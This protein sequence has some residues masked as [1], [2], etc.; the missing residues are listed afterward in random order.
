MR[1]ELALSTDIDRLITRVQYNLVKKNRLSK[2]CILHAECAEPS[3]RKSGE[4]KSKNFIIFIKWYSLSLSLSVE[5]F[6]E[7]GKIGFNTH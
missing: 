4:R 3:E 2:I 5:W 6:A 7:G 1:Y